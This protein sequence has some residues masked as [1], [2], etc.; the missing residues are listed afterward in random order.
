MHDFATIRSISYDNVASARASRKVFET[1]RF[2]EM[3]RRFGL[4][5]R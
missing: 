2:A 1:S 5:A 4:I 3:F